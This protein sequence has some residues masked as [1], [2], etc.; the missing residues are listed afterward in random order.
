MHQC[1]VLVVRLSD[2]ELALF[3]YAEPYP[4][5]QHSADDRLFEGLLEAMKV[6]ELLVDLLFKFADRLVDLY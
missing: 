6:R 5:G 2:H 4:S 3:G 1:I